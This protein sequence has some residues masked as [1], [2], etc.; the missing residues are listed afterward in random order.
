MVE[1]SYRLA[2][3][4]DCYEIAKLKGEV[5]NTTYRGIYSDYALDNYDVERNKRT[6]ES[7]INNPKTSLT[8]AV[9]ADKIIG[10][11]SCGEPY[12]PY[13]HYKQDIGLLYILKNYQRLGMR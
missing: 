13:L 1:I 4:N 5:W 12:R 6:F 11:I 7:I 3:I 9:E 2:T 8:V 10:F